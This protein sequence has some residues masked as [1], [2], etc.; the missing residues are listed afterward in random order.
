MARSFSHADA[1]NVVHAFLT[2]RIDQCC[3]IHVSI[4]STMVDLGKSIGSYAPPPH[5]TSCLYLHFVAVALIVEPLSW[6]R[7]GVLFTSSEY[8]MVDSN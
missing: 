4:P 8:L 3:L 1:V 5:S 2:C 6:S 7:E